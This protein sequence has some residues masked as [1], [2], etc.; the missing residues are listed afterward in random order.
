MDAGVRVD[1][2]AALMPRASVEEHQ[3][4]VA[5][6]VRPA[7]DAGVVTVDLASA[8]DR[9]TAHEMRSPVDLPMFRNS[10][11][12]GYAVVA[13]DVAA[14]PARLRIVGT[15][16]AGSVELPTVSPGAAVRI[17]TGAPIPPG[18]DAVV[19]VEDTRIEGDTVVIVVGRAVGE[20]VRDQGSDMREGEVILPAGLRLAPRHLAALAAA[21]LAAVD[22]RERVGIA[23][24]TTGS[25]IIR[26]GADPG[27]G[28]VFDA[29]AIALQAAIRA[30]GASVV[31]VRH[32]VDDVAEMTAALTDATAV[33]D[34]IVTSGGISAGDFEVVRQVLEPLGARVGTIAMQPGGPQATAVVDGV[35]IVCF[36][37]NPVSTQ[38]SFEVFLAPLLRETAGL[39]AA[40]RTRRILAGGARSVAGKRQF[41]RGRQVAPDRVE[42][43]AGAGSHLVAALAASDVL[44]DIPAEVT[45]L[46]AGDSVETW[47]L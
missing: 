20:Y 30:A 16:A 5:A 15:I 18:A 36:P 32:V 26:P 28:Q 35:P 17:M 23:I 37:G 46:R 22:V 6:L 21:G 1:S 25:E 27:L 2:G 38:L 19:P 42:L 39:P 47:A 12:D 8:L 33:A 24:I 3:A 9:V 31:S 13:S 7:L 4:H 41:L 29:N 14:V 34:L 44:L 10:Q 43:V 11:M 40:V 45:E